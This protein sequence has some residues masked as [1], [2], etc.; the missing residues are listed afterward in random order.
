[1]HHKK[2]DKPLDIL[3]SFHVSMEKAGVDAS[4]EIVKKAVIEPSDEIA[5]HLNLSN[6]QRVFYLERVASLED[7][8]LNFFISYLALTDEQLGKCLAFNGGSLYQ[9]LVEALDVQLKRSLSCL[10]IITAGKIE[11]G[12]LNLPRNSIL[13]QISSKVFGENDVPLEYTRIVYPGHRFKFWFES[14]N[15]QNLS[16]ISDINSRFDR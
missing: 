12:L 10:E 2:I 9:F 16:G 4:V 1:V 14:F 6:N 5:G 11:A 3:Q 13:F 8:P 7:E 15:D